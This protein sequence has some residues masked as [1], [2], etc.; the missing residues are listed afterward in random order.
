MI[1]FTAQYRV[2]DRDR[3][4]ITRGGGERA[5]AAGKPAPGILFAPSKDLLHQGLADR[6]SARGDVEAERVAWK[7]YAAL[8]RLEMLESF[9]RHRAAWE[10]QLGRER[11]VL[12]CFCSGEDAKAERCHRFLLAGFWSS[13]KL[14]ALAAEYR[15]ELTEAERVAPPADIAPPPAILFGATTG[16]STRFIFTDGGG[17]GIVTH[18]RRQRGACRSCGAPALLLCDFPTGHDKRTCD[19]PTCTTCARTVGPDRHFCPAHPISHEEGP[20]P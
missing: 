5:R 7:R 10:A 19:A 3:L 20:K 6:A 1:L 16:R 9:R 8:Y 14:G 11:V 17:G 18:D 15:G 2:H 12:V 4:D 13:P